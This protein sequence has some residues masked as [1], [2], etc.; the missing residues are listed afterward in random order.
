MGAAISLSI[1]THTHATYIHCVCVYIY[2]T[3]P[4]WIREI[5][6]SIF[7]RVL[8][9]ILRVFL[10]LDSSSTQLKTPLLVVSA[11]S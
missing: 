3:H 5:V 1:C 11:P 9:F 8:L 7:R 6:A 2:R 4:H 10:L